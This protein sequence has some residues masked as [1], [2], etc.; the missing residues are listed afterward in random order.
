MISEMPITRLVGCVAGTTGGRV[1]LPT[2]DLVAQPRA[3][4]QISLLTAPTQ[5]RET[6]CK[7][8]NPS[9]CQC[10]SSPSRG[11]GGVPIKKLM[12]AH[13]KHTTTTPQVM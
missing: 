10:P 13:L 7:S 3:P 5:E 11:E 1:C 8:G 9:R 2:Q 4:Q 6:P 12:Q